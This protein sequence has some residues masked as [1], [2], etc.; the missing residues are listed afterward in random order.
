MRLIAELG[1]TMHGDVYRAVDAVDEFALAGATGIKVQLLDP[2]TIVTASGRNYWRTDGEVGSESQ[3]EAFRRW[4]VIPHD[5]WGA[6]VERCAI[7]GVQFIGTPFD[8]AAVGALADYKADAIKI[9]S[10]DITNLPLL[11]AAAR[12]GIPI[13]LSTGA[14]T[15]GEVRAALTQLPLGYDVTLLACT[16]SYPTAVADANLGRISTLRSLGCRVGYSD[17]TTSDTAI[18]FAAATLGATLLEKHCMISM[19]AEPSGDE[20]FALT[21]K[22]FIDYAYSAWAGEQARGTGEIAPVEVEMAARDGARRALRWRCDLPPG[23]EP[24]WV[25]VTTLR[26]CNTGEEQASWRNFQHALFNGWKLHRAV[27]GGDTVLRGDFF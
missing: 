10:G 18:P 5:E 4:G 2:N 23:H 9:A 16:L 15:L 20:K 21:P 8:L 3:R 7:R 19:P 26:P 17:H 14:S 6:V 22:R 24:H 27:R 1:Q 11:W 13:I 25:D 12:T